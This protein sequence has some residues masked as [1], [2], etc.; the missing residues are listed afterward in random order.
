MSR[1]TLPRLRTGL[2]VALIALVSPIGLARGEDEPVVI[3]PYAH[4]LPDAAPGGVVVLLV[5]DAATGKPVAGAR[6]RRCFEGDMDAD[7]QWAPPSGE[8]TT[9]EHGIIEVNVLEVDEEGEPSTDPISPAHWPVFAA[10]YAPAEEY[11]SVVGGV[12]DLERGVDMHGILLD[13]LGKPAVGIDV[14]VKVGCSHAPAL[15]VAKTGKDGRFVLPSVGAEGDLCWSGPGVASDY[16]H[17]VALAQVDLPPGVFRAQPS[18]TIRGRIVGPPTAW[19]EGR[20]VSSDTS[21]RGPRAPVALDGT[22]SLDGWR[23]GDSITITPWSGKV[24]L[25]TSNFRPGGPLLWKLDAPASDATSATLVEVTI[26]VPVPAHGSM[27]FE[28]P[29]LEV[30]FDS[31]ED[32]RRVRTKLARTDEPSSPEV[33]R[34]TLSI[35]PGTYDVGIDQSLR[36]DAPWGEWFAPARVE[37]I[38][39]RTAPLRFEL[40]QRPIVEVDG[41][42]EPVAGVDPPVVELCT[43]TAR[44]SWTQGETPP[45]VAE[46]EEAVVWLLRR[47]KPFPLGPAKDGVRRVV[48]DPRPAATIRVKGG[49]DD[50]LVGFAGSFV[51]PKTIP[52]GIELSWDG[53]PGT[54][55]LSFQDEDGAHRFAKVVIPPERGS[56]IELEASACTE[57]PIGTLTVV[58]PPDVAESMTVAIEG[59]SRLTV[60]EGWVARDFRLKSGAR[61]TLA[62]MAGIRP[63]HLTLE[64]PGPWTYA[65]PSGSIVLRVPSSA[66]TFDE[67]GVLLDGETLG[68]SEDVSTPAEEVFVARGLAAGEHTVLV[69]SPHRSSMQA[70]VRLTDGERRDVVV[71]LPPR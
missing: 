13:A 39:S 20:F 60:E 25:D 1:A 56:L 23:I 48:V 6:V 33:L 18:M 69:G 16:G 30:R 15:R 40:R 14:E 26:E 35:E 54:Y 63:Q 12:I 44:T 11:G 61:V 45:R 50:D 7:A 71:L 28:E 4:S 8:W 34:A 37:R 57:A 51:E 49:T 62:D 43:A 19:P 3:R 66:E 22:F 27:F 2:G 36:R 59:V 9:D 52:G 5:R 10:G 31:H 58:A 17:W 65:I 55:D 21:S 47:W 38:V 41:L 53:P 67:A 64:G 32:G 29:E 42:C 70:R 24:A 68:R 46:N